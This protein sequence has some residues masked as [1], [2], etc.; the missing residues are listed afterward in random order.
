MKTEKKA[1]G[2]GLEAKMEKKKA[3]LYNAK[4]SPEAKEAEDE[5][6]EF[7]KGGKKRA[8]GGSVYGTKSAVRLDKRARGGAMSSPYSSAKGGEM[9]AN[10]TSGKGSGHEDEQPGSME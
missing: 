4:G 8:A 10:Q 3:N 5:K 1:A 2:G 9:P 7:K 6:A